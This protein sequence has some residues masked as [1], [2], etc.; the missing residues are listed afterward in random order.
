[1]IVFYGSTWII[2]TQHRKIPQN[3]I[4]SLLKQLLLPERSISDDIIRDMLKQHKK[5]KHLDLHD[6]FDFLY[7]ALQQFGKCYICIDA[8]DEYG[9]KN[10][11]HFFMGPKE[12]LEPKV[13]TKTGVKEPGKSNQTAA[14]KPGHSTR[15][16]I[17]G[18]PHTEKLVQQELTN[19]KSPTSFTLRADKNDINMYVAHELN[20]EP[21][22]KDL[23]SR[24]PGFIED[25]GTRIANQ[26]D[27]M[28]VVAPEGS[29]STV[30]TIVFRY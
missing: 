12:I 28:L 8:L 26:S 21:D 5:Q 6:A 3:I 18:R 7:R 13:D 17:M 4:G 14:T 1:M 2:Q 24:H 16:F 11:K 22:T 23:E 15:I 27:G 30:L 10:A 9:G 29:I 25:I 19:S 20:V